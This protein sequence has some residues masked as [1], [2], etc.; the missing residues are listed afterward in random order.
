M[1]FFHCSGKVDSKDCAAVILKS[2]EDATQCALDAIQCLGGNG[3]I[4]GTHTVPILFCPSAKCG[5]F[6]SFPVSLFNV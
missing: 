2:A 6:L 3:Y 4:N 1:L 5:R